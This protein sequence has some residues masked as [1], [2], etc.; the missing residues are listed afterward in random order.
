MKATKVISIIG[1]VD[2]QRQVEV[3]S[4][5]RVTALAGIQNASRSTLV[6]RLI[7][8]DG[9]IVASAPVMRLED[10]G[11]GCCGEK[12]PKDP[13]RGPFV[14]QAMVPD[15]EPG[16]E[17]RIV[18]LGKDER[19]EDKP[20]WVRRAPNNEPKIASF[21]VRVSGK[22]GTA[23]WDTRAGEGAQLEFALQFS[24]DDGRSWNGLV[25]GLREAGYQFDISTLPEGKLVFRLLAH[26][27]FFTVTATSKPVKIS[28]RP[29]AVSILHPQ[30]G[31]VLLA[32]DPMRL[33]GTGSTT[34]GE[35][36]RPDQCGWRID[37]KT[38]ANGIDTF[39]DAPP[40]GKH[41]C[42]LTVDSPQGKTE[43][44]VTFQTVNP[45][46]PDTSAARMKRRPR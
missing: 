32:G 21:D 24:K 30:E 1:V 2:Q 35:R 36:I 14:F 8:R 17:L 19:E 27:G 3:R 23:R 18:R 20:V 5:M 38:V 26:D 39:V 12:E 44:E 11:C 31:P 45:T 40:E 28:G 37:G 46:K 6:A 7:G 42:T 34:T 29:P 4:V 15:V 33:W 41:R 22:G 10:Q 9:N 16:A 43:A 13:T 25:T